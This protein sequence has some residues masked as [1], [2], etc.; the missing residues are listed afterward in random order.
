MSTRTKKYVKKQVVLKVVFFV[1]VVSS[2]TH[3]AFEVSGG[4]KDP[5]L[6]KP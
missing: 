6:N 1:V 4:Y 2:L 3:G 5:V